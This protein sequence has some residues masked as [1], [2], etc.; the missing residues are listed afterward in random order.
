[1]QGAHQLVRAEMEV[2]QIHQETDY[3][4]FAYGP[5][6][7]EG[8]QVLDFSNREKRRQKKTQLFLQGT[9]DYRGED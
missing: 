3:D 6:F 4:Y 8:E 5:T 1:M 9:L 7:S 2:E